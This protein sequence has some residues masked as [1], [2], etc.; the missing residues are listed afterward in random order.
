MPQPKKKVKVIQEDICA[1]SQKQ[2]LRN[3]GTKDGERALER[4]LRL[5]R[6]GAFRQLLKKL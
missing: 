1:A 5:D 3:K 2:V 4:G 6:G